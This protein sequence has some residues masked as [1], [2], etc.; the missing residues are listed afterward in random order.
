MSFVRAG[1]CLGRRFGIGKCTGGGLLRYLGGTFCRAVG[2]GS[3][4][5]RRLSW[6]E[7]PRF[8]TLTC[9]GTPFVLLKRMARA[10]L[11]GPRWHLLLSGRVSALRSGDAGVYLPY[12]T[13]VPFEVLRCAESCMLF[14]ATKLTKCEPFSF[15]VIFPDRVITPKSS[16]FESGDCVEVDR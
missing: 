12:G 6:S 15:W 14:P 2:K 9:V 1:S 11:W 5:F 10:S 16:S 7:T 13:C 8:L 3:I 4:R